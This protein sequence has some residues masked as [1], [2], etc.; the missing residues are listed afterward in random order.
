MLNLEDLEQ[1]VAFYKYGTLTK[2]AEEFMISQ[3]TITR[4]M[5]RVEESFGVSLFTRF[6]NKIEIN[7]TGK[8]AAQVAMRLLESAKQCETEVKTF[9]QQLHTIIVESCAPAPLW[10]FMPMLNRKYLNKTIT[11]K[12]LDD[13]EQLEYDL[14]HNQCN[15]AILTYPIE[16]N[17]IQCIPYLEEHLSICV[18]P[19]HELAKY[20]ELTTKEINGYNCLLS[21][22]IGFW[23]NFH[24]R[25]LPSSKFFVQTDEDAF[26]ELIIASSLPCFTTNLA[27]DHYTEPLKNRIS[28]P[29]T[30]PE[31]N[32]TYYICSRKKDKYEFKFTQ[33]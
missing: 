15:I 26:K 33:K 14:L 6:A 3:P 21:S 20:K 13:M 18:P 16:N 10:S 12:L 19:S 24:K 27:F 32:V 5:K 31:A 8:M 22:D 4:T 29:I 2:V 30:D 23:G 17:E 9:D 7:E 25:M 11:S 28:I 1:F